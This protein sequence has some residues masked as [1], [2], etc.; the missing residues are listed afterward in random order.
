[1][2]KTYLT[3]PQQSCQFYPYYSGTIFTM[4]KNVA[5]SK[6]VHAII[7]FGYASITNCGWNQN[8]SRF[9]VSRHHFWYRQTKINKFICFAVWKIDLI[10]K[11]FP[12]KPSHIQRVIF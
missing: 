9:N 7:G 10:K 5:I 3:E 12:L 1:M 6:C 8:A 11:H 2:I 4:Q